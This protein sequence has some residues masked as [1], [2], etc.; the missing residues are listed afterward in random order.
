M[1]FSSPGAVQ[2]ATWL[3]LELPC[4]A[5]PLPHQQ[6]ILCSWGPWVLAGCGCGLFAGWPFPQSSLAPPA[7]A[8]EFAILPFCCSQESNIMFSL[9]CWDLAA[10]RSLCAVFNTRKSTFSPPHCPQERKP[11]S[12]TRIPPSFGRSFCHFRWRK[13]LACSNWVCSPSY[14]SQN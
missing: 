7:S 9:P 3:N 5:L 2:A 8:L 10:D 12:R 13:G 14:V 1:H 4:C 6:N 11:G